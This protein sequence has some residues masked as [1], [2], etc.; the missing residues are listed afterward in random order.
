MTPISV[1][2]PCAISDTST[3]SILAPGTALRALSAT[4]R[5]ASANASRATP[6]LTPPASVLCGTSRDTTLTAKG[7]WSVADS[8]CRVSACSHK[9]LFGD[10]NT[11]GPQHRLALGL[12]E[13]DC[14]L[15]QGH[16]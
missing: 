15:G 5:A 3:P 13:R 10:R 8:R 11:E 12:V 6:S 7:A 16:G 4:D 9:H 2:R 14:A 1:S